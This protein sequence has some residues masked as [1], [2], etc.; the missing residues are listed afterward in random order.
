MTTGAAPGVQK[1]CG[2]LLVGVCCVWGELVD[3][4]GGFVGGGCILSIFLLKE[5]SCNVMQLVFHLAGAMLLFAW[6]DER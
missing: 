2:L 3:V 4:G 5:I 1:V 6:D